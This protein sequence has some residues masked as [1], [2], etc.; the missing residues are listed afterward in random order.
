[1]SDINAKL[2]EKLATLEAQ[3]AAM[4][5]PAKHPSYDPADPIGSLQAQGADLDTLTKM[6]VART[7]GEQAPPEWRALTAIGPQVAATRALE[8]KLN[9]L[10]DTVTQTTASMTKKAV[11]ES[12]K[13]VTSDKTKYPA[14]A[15]A[16]AADPTFFDEDL[17]AHSG[18][19]EDFAQRAEAK[20]QKLGYAT[21]VPTASEEDADTSDDEVLD[22]AAPSQEDL[23]ELG[24]DP[25][26]DSIVANGQSTQAESAEAA[27][28]MA[29][30]PPP[31]RERA[32][33]GQMPPQRGPK[34]GVFTADD[35]ARL[36][37]EVVRKYSRPQR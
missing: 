13:A 37:D 20:L 21:P 32:L 11:R 34:V 1:M 6:L 25:N 36:R 2:L 26:D 14:L 17:D 27:H 29:A 23:Q 30:A 18:S 9:A 12:F 19:A 8:A 7:L 31:K 15:K 35:H 33:N 22:S 10:A 5:K 16:L 3:V 28:R 4:S 24:F